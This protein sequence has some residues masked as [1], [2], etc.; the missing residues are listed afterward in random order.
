M[1]VFEWILCVGLYLFCGSVHSIIFNKQFEP[2]GQMAL[3]FLWPVIWLSCVVAVPI[4]L[5][6]FLLLGWGRD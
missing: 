5:V 2:A 3:I 4:Y 1:S 6:G